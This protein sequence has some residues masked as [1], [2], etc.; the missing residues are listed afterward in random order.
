MNILVAVSSALLSAVCFGIGSVMQ[1]EAARRAAMWKSLRLQLLFDLAR[2]P[3]W[4]AGIGLSVCSFAFLGLALAH[5]PLALVLPLAATD[6][7]FALP[8]LA[9]RQREPLTGS[10]KTGII[11]TA[12]GVAVFLT[13]LPLAPRTSLPAV[14]DWVPALAVVVGVVALLVPVGVSSPPRL[15]TAVYAVCAAVTLALFDSL[16]KSTAGRFRT[17][18]LEALLHW[19]PYALIAVGVT[20]L[21]LSQSAFQS[22]SLAVSLPVIDT[23]EPIGAVAIGL[24]VFDEQLAVTGWT[25]TVQMLGAATAVT[26]IVLLGRS[27]LATA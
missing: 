17:E 5:G 11:C 6:L 27:P 2:R 16:T 13:V 9:S 1:H 8:F 14:H 7:L 12:G 19:E 4:L 25:L 15:R 20:G 26:G 23:L 18:S 10:E 3:G 24:A 22:G 21:V